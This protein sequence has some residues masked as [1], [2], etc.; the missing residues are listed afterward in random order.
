MK[1]TTTSLPG[2]AFSHFKAASVHSVAE[3]IYSTLAMIPLLFGFAPTAWCQSVAAMIPK[4]KEDL[5][6]AKLQ[7]ITLLNAI[8]NHK[9]KWVGKEIMK[10]GEKHGLL[11]KEQYGSRKK[12]SAGQH[13]LNK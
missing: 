7:L 2:P 6:P 11:A 9:N 3:E 5:Q 10:N 4:K 13:T 12:K 1:E 8:C